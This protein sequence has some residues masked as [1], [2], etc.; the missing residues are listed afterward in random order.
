MD[1]SK[2]R[3]DEADDGESSRAS[4]TLPGEAGEDPHQGAVRSGPLAHFAP[5]AWSATPSLVTPEQG[6]KFQ[7][8]PEFPPT[9]DGGPRGE[10]QTRTLVSDSITSRPDA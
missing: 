1:V 3:R 8:Q 7:V 6:R 2:F 10:A 5:L 4:G 9:R